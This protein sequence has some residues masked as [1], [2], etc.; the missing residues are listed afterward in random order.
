[1]ANWIKIISLALQ[2][3]DAAKDLVAFIGMTIDMYKLRKRIEE[4]N[5]VIDKQV[6]DMLAERDKTLE[7]IAKGEE[8]TDEDVEREMAAAR[9]FADN[10]G[11]RRFRGQ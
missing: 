9:K 7:K 5:E 6:R 4:K 1:M 2:F 11:S 10:F 8:I 3:V